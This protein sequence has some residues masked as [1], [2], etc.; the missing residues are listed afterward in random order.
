[1]GG[2]KRIAPDG[3]QAEPGLD[4]IGYQHNDRLDRKSVRRN[5]GS[6][7]YLLE[8]AGSAAIRVQ[9]SGRSAWMLDHLISAGTAGISARDLPAGGRVSAFVNILRKGG[10]MIETKSEPNGGEFGGHHGIYRLV[11]QIVRIDGAAS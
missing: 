1:M 5:A 10:I 3:W 6:S 11:C 2:K 9:F 7:C 4:S 8:M